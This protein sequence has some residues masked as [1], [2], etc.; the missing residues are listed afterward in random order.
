MNNLERMSVSQTNDKIFIAIP[1]DL[2]IFAQGERPDFPLNVR[3]REKMSAW[4]LR[5]LLHF[6]GDT[7]TGVT[8]FEAFL[9]KMFIEA[10]E[11]AEDWIEAVR[12]E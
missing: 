11:N 8:E 1:K 4:I 2:M 7:E 9:D 12:D 5:Y 10:Y 6:G 3:D